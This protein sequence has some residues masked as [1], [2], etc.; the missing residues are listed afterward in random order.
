MIVGLVILLAIVQGLTE[1]LPV[2]SSGHLR[3]LQIGFGVEEPQTLFDV[4]LH[5]GTL[6]PVLFVYR[7]EIGRM[8]DGLVASARRRA[9]DAQTTQARLAMLIVV[10]SIPTGIIGIGLGDA[11]ESLTLDLAW[12]SGALAVN[13]GILFG[14]GAVQRRQSETSARTLEALTVRD[15]LFVGTVQGFAVFRGISR[16]GS[17]ITAGMLSGLDREAAAAFSFLLSVP[18][19]GGAL[20]LKMDFDV[21]TDDGLG[22]YLL[23]GALACISGTVALLVLLRLLRR[24]QLH[25]FAWYCLAIAG[26]GMYWHFIG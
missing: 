3:L 9:T 19:I 20:L 21:I 2:S 25:H 13:A 10:G 17:T 1:F 22:I 26:L 12:V 4:V 16:S 6:F 7:R 8:V 15:A 18:A 5:V 23:G 14:L 24:G 11:M